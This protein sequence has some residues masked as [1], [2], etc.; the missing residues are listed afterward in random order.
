MAVGKGPCRRVC[1]HRALN[2]SLVLVDEAKKKATAPMGKPSPWTPLTQSRRCST[3]N[4]NGS[5][6][7]A[8][9]GTPLSHRQ[10]D[11]PTHSGRPPK[12]TADVVFTPAQVRMRNSSRGSRSALP[13]VAAC[14]PR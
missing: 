8:R 9:Y 10:T 12:Q 4:S 11:C 7:R 5:R 2:R 3:S 14:R 6:V 1:A 13:Y